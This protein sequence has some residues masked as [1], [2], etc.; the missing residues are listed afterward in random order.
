MWLVVYMCTGVYIHMCA[1][2]REGG[3]YGD[4]DDRGE[5]RWQLSEQRESNVMICF[6]QFSDSGPL[7][8]ACL[9]SPSALTP[10]PP[11]RFNGEC[12][13]IS[14]L[15]S[16][17]DNL[18]FLSQFPGALRAQGKVWETT[19]GR[20]CSVKLVSRGTWEEQT[21]FFL[22]TFLCVTHIHLWEKKKA[23]WETQD[24]YKEFLWKF[25]KIRHVEIWMSLL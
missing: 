1:Q 9:P 20:L 24:L 25:I 7:R 21:Y 15:S 3:R 12:G 16:F 17:G 2:N 8:S 11:P 4:R 22:E 13:K 10:T 14:C 23:S 19:W 6:S 18:C 5:G